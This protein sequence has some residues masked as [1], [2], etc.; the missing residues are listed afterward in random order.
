[1]PPSTPDPQPSDA[2]GAAGSGARASAA[3]SS[4]PPTR[5]GKHAGT[6]RLL[7]C[8]IEP[9]LPS[10]LA[11]YEV[12]SIAL[13]DDEHDY[14]TPDLAILPVEWDEDESWLVSP[15]DVALAVEVIAYSE[16]PESSGGNNGRYAR[17]GVEVL[18]VIDP[19]AGEWSLF[20]RP[21][22]G[23]YQDRVDGVYGQLIEL[24][25]PLPSPLG[26]SALPIYG[27]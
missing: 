13:S 16:T 1:M 11:P 9:I 24:P 2:L 17:A 27:S 20:T 8:R 10:G 26:T 15:R 7:R 21:K 3:A 6:V 19:G 23:V 22:D 5:R 18:L 14:V 25:S 12:S 4:R